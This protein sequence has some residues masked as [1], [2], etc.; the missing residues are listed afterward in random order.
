M[1]FFALFIYMYIHSITVWS[2]VRLCIDYMALEEIQHY[3]VA[4]STGYVS[5]KPVSCSVVD[6]QGPLQMMLTKRM[7]TLQ[8]RKLGSISLQ[9]AQTLSWDM[10]NGKWEMGSR[11]GSS[12]A[13]LP[14]SLWHQRGENENWSIWFAV[15][16]IATQNPTKNIV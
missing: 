6:G 9:K 3:A 2:F 15:L 5:V 11:D 4:E 8:T 7:L 10:G 16:N 1:D 12:Y 13:I 14:A